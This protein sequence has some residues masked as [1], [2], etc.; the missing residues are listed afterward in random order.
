M[1]ISLKNINTHKISIFRI[2]ILLIIAVILIWTFV[3]LN[4]SSAEQIKFRV[5]VADAFS[6]FAIGFG[7]LATGLGGLSLIEDWIKRQNAREEQEE[8]L[9]ERWTK[10]Y[11]PEMYGETYRLIQDET[12][13]GVLYIQD[14]PDGGKHWI[15]NPATLRDLGLDYSQVESVDSSSFKNIKSA[16]NINTKPIE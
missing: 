10:I 2:L 4:S 12:V 3:W 8:S 13:P 7:A 16:G 1:K 14:L 15:T 5:Q 9:K 11:P 6:K